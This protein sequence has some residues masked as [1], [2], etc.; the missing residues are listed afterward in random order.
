MRLP[1]LQE[2]RRRRVLQDW[3]LRVPKK[4]AGLRAQ[5]RL[6]RRNWRSSPVRQSIHSWW[7]AQAG[8]RGQQPTPVGTGGL[9]G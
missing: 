6:L 9:C 7:R 3:S 2:G 5:V 8:A 1:A 4:R